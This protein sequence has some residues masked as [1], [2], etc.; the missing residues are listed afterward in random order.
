VV[1]FGS[2]A[3]LKEIYSLQTTALGARFYYADGDTY[4]SV[5]QPLTTFTADWTV[6]IPDHGGSLV[7]D[8][9]SVSG[10]GAAVSGL[11]VGLGG[12]PGDGTPISALA[13]GIATLS[14]G[15]ATVTDTTIKAGA[16]IMLTPHHTNN[17][18]H[19]SINAI[20]AG[21]DFEITSSN[22]S[23][24]GEVHWIRINLQ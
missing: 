6:V 17:S 5:F 7:I 1:S 16:V 12:I 8:D 19:M 14:S 20:N 4:S 10:N 22:G 24:H 2:G 9:N 23:D 21:S 15:T 18:G 11:L 13:C 3:S